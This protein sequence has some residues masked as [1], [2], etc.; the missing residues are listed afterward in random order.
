MPLSGFEKQREKIVE[1]GRRL[2]QRGYVA[3]NDGNLSVRLGEGLFAVTVTGV[4]KGFMTADD[5]V[6]VNGTG[7]LVEGGL[8]NEIGKP[9][10]EL[11][12]HLAIYAR[13]SD[14][15]AICHAHPSYAT[16]FASCGLELPRPFL[17]EVVVNLGRQIP[18]I[19]YAAPGSGELA[20]KV[21]IASERANALLLANH[22]AVTVGENLPQAWFRMETLEHYAQVAYLTEALGGAA[23]LSDDEVEAFESDSAE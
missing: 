21:A 9:T 2:Y 17:P 16:V 1:I 6:I 4:S 10:S 23:P 13:R 8:L 5:V 7:D 12:L 22:G 11:Q 19:P 18:L 3:A 20:E 14:V 15:N